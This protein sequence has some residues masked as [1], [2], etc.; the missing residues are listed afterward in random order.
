MICFMN[1]RFEITDS[2]TY[3]LLLDK[4]KEMRRNPTEAESALWN[5]LSGDKMGA[6][7]HP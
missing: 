3:Q 1:N 2:A 4:A 5:Y 7:F 6:H